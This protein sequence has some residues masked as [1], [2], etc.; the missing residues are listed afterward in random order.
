MMSYNHPVRLSLDYIV[1]NLKGNK[2]SRV[3]V[4][5]GGFLKHKLKSK[6]DE[7]EEAIK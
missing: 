2:T 3:D 7:N 6:I 1:S 4:E 5:S